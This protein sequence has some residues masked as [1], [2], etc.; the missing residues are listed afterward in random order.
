MTCEGGLQRA[1]VC[2]PCA[3]DGAGRWCAGAPCLV[4]T[5]AA[6]A[7][8]AAQSPRPQ[9]ERRRSGTYGF[10][11]H[12]FSPRVSPGIQVKASKT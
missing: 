5:L 3:R 4:P 8:P 6:A 7:F 10:G 2:G 12:V 11:G 1:H 9:P